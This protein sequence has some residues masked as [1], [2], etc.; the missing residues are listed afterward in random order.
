MA[1]ARCFILKHY[2]SQV[3]I[4]RHTRVSKALW[5]LNAIRRSQAKGSSRRGLGAVAEVHA[6]SC[7]FYLFKI[8]CF[9]NSAVGSDQ[10]A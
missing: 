9:K 8:V 6:T 1:L 5:R 3:A 4:E 10:A 2:P 7:F